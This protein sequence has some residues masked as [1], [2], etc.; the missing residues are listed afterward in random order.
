MCVFFIIIF[1]K[2]Q[3]FGD[4]YSKFKLLLLHLYFW[5]KEISLF[6]RTRLYRN[7]TELEPLMSD[8]AYDFDFQETR[9]LKEERRI[10][11]VSFTE[12]KN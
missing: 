1:H 10:Y 8:E 11:A 12:Q 5:S 3:G 4:T 2:L 9:M 7:G 6:Y